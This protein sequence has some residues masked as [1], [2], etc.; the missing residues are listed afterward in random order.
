VIQILVLLTFLSVF[1]KGV[2]SL[3]GSKTCGYT[4]AI[5][6]RTLSGAAYFALRQ[7]G[8]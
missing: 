6:C 1:V 7:L 8:S 4:T 3:Y 2:A 5:T